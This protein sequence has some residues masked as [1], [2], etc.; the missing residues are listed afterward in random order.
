MNFMR[1]LA[2]ISVSFMLE[3]KNL[4]LLAKNTGLFPNNY[5]AETRWLV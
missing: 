5:G 1:G 3:Q 2:N 4:T